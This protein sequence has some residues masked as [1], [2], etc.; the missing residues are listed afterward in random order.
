MNFDTK[1]KL[2]VLDSLELWQKMNVGA[3][4]TSGIGGA[5]NVL[6][7]PYL[8]ARQPVMIHAAPDAAEL[9]ALLRKALDKE[10]VLAVYTRDLFATNN[11]EDNRA[12]GARCKTSELVGLAAFGK[13]NQVDK[14]FKEL[15]LHK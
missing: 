14:L 15:P 2:A 13:K 5:G 10:V 1:I 11:D 3:F 4:L 7:Q 12:A 8:D 9:S 6:G